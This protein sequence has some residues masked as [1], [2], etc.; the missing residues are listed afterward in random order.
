MR[1]PTE[2]DLILRRYGEAPDADAIQSHLAG[3]AS[4]R[5]ADERLAETLS[6]LDAAPLPERNDR[7][8][9]EVWNRVRVRL[10]AER[11]RGRRPFLL[12][13]RP[14]LLG[15]ALAALLAAAF[16]AGRLWPRA[17]SGAPPAGARE[18]I[19][20]VAVGD[21]LDRSQM[22]LLEFLHAPSGGDGRER[23]WAEELAAA[24][25]LYRQTAAQDGDARVAAALDDLE[26]VLLEIAHS[27]SAESREALRRRLDSDGT[28]FK[29]RVIRS[30]VGR[31]E[32]AGLAA[33]AR[34]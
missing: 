7:Y 14:L 33:A 19:L 13:L 34:S 20:L 12:A 1:H 28:L 8:G 17:N 30:E 16:L 21:H 6:L 9:A 5:A 24:N 25:R 11:P 3:C 4:C 27:P 2:D 32:T 26:R 15:G 31:R 22:V 23:A 10:A 18:R 29:V